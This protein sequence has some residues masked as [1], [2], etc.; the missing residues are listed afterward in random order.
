M[1]ISVIIPCYNSEQWIETA[2]RSA[3]EQTYAPFEI[4]VIDDGS[5]DRSVSVVE[6]SKYPVKLIQAEHVNAAR[7][8]NLGIEVAAGDWIAFLDADDFWYPDHLKCAVQSLSGTEH[9]AYMADYDI[10]DQDAQYCPDTLPVARD[11]A[12]AV[13]YLD[14][15]IITRNI[16][17]GHG[18]VLMLRERSQSVGSFDADFPRRHDIE[19]FL[20]VVHGHTWMY[21]NQPVFAHRVGRE[22]RISANEGECAYYLLKMLIKNRALYE[23]P[24]MDQRLALAARTCAK[25][26]LLEDSFEI[27]RVWL[28]LCKPYLKWYLK[29]CFSLAYY[30][31]TPFRYFVRLREKILYGS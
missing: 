3:A 7:A 20:R 25:H 15:D 11:G 5:S 12:L 14:R 19:H 4:I 16:G 1:K 18:S 26:A 29:P 9:V 22:S 8:R 23:I 30:A 13:A 21:R 6:N 27:T 28:S 10:V 24:E 31:R 17:F 2:I